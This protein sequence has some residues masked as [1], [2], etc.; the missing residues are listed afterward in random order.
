MKFIGSNLY[1]IPGVIEA[2]S[3]AKTIL[4]IGAGSGKYGM[5][6]HEYCRDLEYIDAIEPKVEN[7]DNPNEGW[8]RNIYPLGFLEEE[9]DEEYDIGLMAAVIGNFTIDEA[10][11]VLEL[12]CKRF[13]ITVEKIAH[14]HNRQWSKKELKE[15]LPDYTIKELP[16]EW[17]VV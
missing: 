10:K 6:A 9:E 2:I 3:D 14:G 13:V 7:L 5:L 16:S 17:L 12:P 15:L 4:D 1:S 11:K 8:Y